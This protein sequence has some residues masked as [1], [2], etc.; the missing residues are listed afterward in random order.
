VKP[1]KRS[2]KTVHRIISILYRKCQDCRLPNHQFFA[3]Q[4][5]PAVSDIFGNGISAQ[6]AETSV[7]MKGQNVHMFR[8]IIHCDILCDTRLHKTDRLVDCLYPFHVCTSFAEI[9][10]NRTVFFLPDIFCFLLSNN[11]KCGNDTGFSIPPIGEIFCE[12]KEAGT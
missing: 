8:H 1:A 11:K 10:Y 6:H 7:K 4:R 5:Q 12:K 9:Q 2:G 3:R